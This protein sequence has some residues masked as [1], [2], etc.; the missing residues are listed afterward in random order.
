MTFGLVYAEKQESFEP[1]EAYQNGQLK[2]ELK[3]ITAILDEED[4]PVIMVARN[5]K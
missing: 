4:N 5:K 1:V 3:E 2:G